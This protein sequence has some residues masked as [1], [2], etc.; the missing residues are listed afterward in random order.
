MLESLL[1]LE[2][3]VSADLDEGDVV[4]HVALD[5]LVVHVDVADV[6][7]DVGVEL[8]GVVYVPFTE[9][10]SEKKNKKN[11]RNNDNGYFRGT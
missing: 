11:M 6:E 7:L 8:G 3:R 9:A 1:F 10:N 5:E 2:V 4:V